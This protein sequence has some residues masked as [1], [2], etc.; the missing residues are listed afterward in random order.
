MRVWTSAWI[1][2][3][4][5]VCAAAPASSRS[6][7]RNSGL[8]SA[9]STQLA[10]TADGMVDASRR[11]ACVL[12]RQRAEVDADERRAM[13]RGAPGAGG[14][15]AGEARR[16]DQEK[17]DPGGEDRQGGQPLEGPGVGPVDVLDEEEQRRRRFDRS[18]DVAQRVTSPARAPS[19]S[20]L[21]RARAA[22]PA[23]RRRAGGAG[24]GS[25]DRHRPRPARALKRL[26]PRRFVGGAIDAEHAARE[27]AH[28]AR[29]V[30]APKS[31]TGAR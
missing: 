31:R 2:P 1:E 5:L 25:L 16:H 26:A 17:R 24:R 3:G 4:R 27:A 18:D 9:R 21:R 6:W 28:G 15:V 22:R 29:P 19:C 11:E 30:S 14:R 7:S 8:P 20:S 23:A 13:E 12:G 10:T